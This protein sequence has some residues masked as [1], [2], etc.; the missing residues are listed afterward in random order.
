MNIKGYKAFNEKLQCDPDPRKPF[1]YK[2]GETY[3]METHPI[4]C[5]QG[6][7]LCAN[8]SDCY[9]YYPYPKRTRICEVEA[10]GWI[11]FS[12]DFLA[13]GGRQGK[14]VT[15]M[16]TIL[17]ELTKDEIA[18]RLMEEAICMM[19]PG[20]KASLSLLSDIVRSHVGNDIVVEGGRI[21]KIATDTGFPPTRLSGG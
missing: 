5:V 10:T 8:V 4:L 16:I 21:F 18:D 13:S 7:H 12:D 11:E 9:N 19:D 3:S 2:V 6:F 15:N 20:K 1:Q 17:R 14:L